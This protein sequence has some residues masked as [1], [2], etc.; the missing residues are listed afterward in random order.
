MP[1]LDIDPQCYGPTIADLLGGDRLPELGPGT[2]NETARP[3]I[4]ALAVSRTL[5]GQ[6]IVD[7]LAAKCCVAGLWLW[8]DFLDESHEQSN[9][10]DTPDGSYWHGIMH[11]REPDYGNAKYWFRHVPNHAIYDPLAEA[12]RKLAPAIRH[13]PLDESSAYLLTQKTWNPNAFVDL[14]EAVA[15]ERSQTGQLARE[16]A[17]IEWQ[18][19]FDHCFRKATGT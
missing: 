5:G 2:P 12:A 16:V 19:L 15:D 18:L 6:K 3:K 14:C 9:S 10:I 8:H 4:Q 7:H 1:P 13:V 17:R 11:R